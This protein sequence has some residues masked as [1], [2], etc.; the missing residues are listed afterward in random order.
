MTAN[1]TAQFLGDSSSWHTVS[2]Q[3]WSVQSLWGGHIVS[4]A[5]PGAA[6]VRRIL[7]GAQHEQ[8]YE[9]PLYAEER[10]ELLLLLI[11]NDVLAIELPARTMM[12]PDEAETVLTLRK[13][14]RAFSLRTW[15]N[16][17]A[18]ARVNAILAALSGLVRRTDD[19]TPIYDGP[20]QH[21]RDEPS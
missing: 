21:N 19:L 13:G 4:V 20:Y 5:G 6:V 9:V 2:L 18:D 3:L 11:G 1:L 17:P 10:A 16:D 14:R 12:A 15:A 7:P 8:R